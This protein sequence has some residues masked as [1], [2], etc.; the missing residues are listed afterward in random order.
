MLYGSSYANG[1]NI[2][3]YARATDRYGNVATSP[4]ST[5]AA[6]G[7]TATGESG[8]ISISLSTPATTLL[9]G[10]PHGQSAIATAYAY[11][12]NGLASM[13][14]YANGLLV[15]A[16]SI[17][18]FP[19]SNTCTS[20]LYSSDYANSAPISVYVQATD[21]NGIVSTSSTVILTLTSN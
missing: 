13:G 12:A 9:N 3:V 1:S 15:R 8:N 18:N 5:L 20:T 6:Q 14:I 21:R 19:T 11:S 2:S 16:C 17:A 4:T 10:Q 7:S